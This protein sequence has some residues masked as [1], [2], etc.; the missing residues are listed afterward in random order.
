MRKTKELSCGHK[1]DFHTPVPQPGDNAWCLTCNTL[2]VIPRKTRQPW[3]VA[4]GRARRL[5]SNPTSNNQYTKGRSLSNG[6]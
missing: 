3:T 5:K 1:Q 6:T 2:Q 4:E